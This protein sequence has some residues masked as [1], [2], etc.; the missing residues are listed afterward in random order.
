MS[1]ST[2]CLHHLSLLLALLVVPTSLLQSSSEELD[3]K[4]SYY[5]IKHFLDPNVRIVLLATFFSHGIKTNL[6]DETRTMDI[7][8]HEHDQHQLLLDDY[9][10][11]KK[12]FIECFITLDLFE[13]QTEELTLGQLSELKT[14]IEMLQTKAYASYFNYR[15]WATIRE[16]FHD[17]FTCAARKQELQEYILNNV[18]PTYERVRWGK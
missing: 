3:E 12:R 5:R 8:K 13:P 7:E 16:E 1:P 10:Q 4:I 14:F 2:S 18:L 17:T 15:K 11:T 6:G 9:R